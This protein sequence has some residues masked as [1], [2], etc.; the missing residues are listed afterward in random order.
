MMDNVLLKFVMQKNVLIAILIFIVP[1]YQKF[2][3]NFIVLNALLMFIVPIERMLNV[4]QKYFFML[5]STSNT[6][7]PCDSDS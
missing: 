6:C 3:L 4:C 2:V 5:G 1:T 7:I